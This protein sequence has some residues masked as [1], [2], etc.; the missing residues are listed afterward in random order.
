MPL[1]ADAVAPARL[2]TVAVVGMAKN[3]GKTTA[4]TSMIR[5]AA[6]SGARIGVTSAGRDGEAFDAVTGLAKP[7][8]WL[9][10]EA[11]VV[12]AEHTLARSAAQLV[13]VRRTGLLT[14]AGELVAYEVEKPGNVEIIG[15]NQEAIAEEMVEH[16]RSLGAEIV[17]VDGAADR[18]FSAAPAVSEAVVLATGAALSESMDEVL[19][20]TRDTIRVLSLP[21]FRASEAEG[22]STESAV[23]RA[24]QELRIAAVDYDGKVALFPGRTALGQ[25]DKVAAMVTGETRVLAIG[26][27]APGSLLSALITRARRLGI[28]LSGFE[29]VVRDPTRI[30][31]DPREVTRYLGLGG[32][33]SV[34]QPQRI[35]ALTVNPTSP[36]HPGFDAREFLAKASLAGGEVLPDLYAYDV[37][38]GARAQGGVVID[39]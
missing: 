9:P 2:S 15:P 29:V 32:R 13:P 8:I 24:I 14:S 17:F 12:T 35:L 4:L 19:A 10:R 18:V 31:M 22:L 11:L 33:I 38:L 27:A 20:M 6:A 16:L 7:P 23:L 1:Y 37:V 5:E 30:A 25:A 26:R 28:P 39:G 36:Y 34:L 3:C 21:R